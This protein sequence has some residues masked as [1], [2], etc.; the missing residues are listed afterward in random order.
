LDQPIYRFHILIPT[1]PVRLLESPAFL[2]DVLPVH[3][4]LLLQIDVAS[5]VIEGQILPFPQFL[6]VALQM[7][8]TWQIRPHPPRLVLSNL[9]RSYGEFVVEVL[10]V[11][12]LVQQVLAQARP[13]EDD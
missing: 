13:A 6:A 7:L 4:Q 8:P 3:P 1:L 12:E 2:N 10:N 9:I 5:Q 11:D